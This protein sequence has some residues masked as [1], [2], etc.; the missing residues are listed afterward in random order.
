VEAVRRSD[1]G[2]G[3]ALGPRPSGWHIECSVMAGALLG[4]SFDIHGGGVDLM[5]P[6]HETKSAQS[7]GAHGG[8]TLANIWMHNGFLQVEGEK[9]SKASATSSRYENCLNCGLV[10]Q[11]G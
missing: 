3:V 4:D 6:H 11:F 8:H 1:A 9:M 5:F 7:E 10:M 2:L